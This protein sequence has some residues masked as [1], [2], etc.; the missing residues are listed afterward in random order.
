MISSN[1]CGSFTDLYCLGWTLIFTFVGIERPD[2]TEKY[3]AGRSAT[4]IFLCDKKKHKV[5]EEDVST[6]LDSK[7]TPEM[8]NIIMNLICYDYKERKFSENES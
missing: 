7:V 5:I 8:K 3:T 1:I 2:V 6:L 4:K